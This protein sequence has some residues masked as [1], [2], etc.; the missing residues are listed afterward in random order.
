MLIV[1]FSLI[2]YTICTN[3]DEVLE[4][5]RVAEITIDA[6]WMLHMG[7]MFTTAFLK[8]VDWVTDIRQIAFNY[9]KANFLIDLVTTLPTLIT[10]YSVPDL[11]YLKLL[12]MYYIGR[13]T[14]IIKA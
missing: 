11:Y 4:V 7:M 1:D 8:D 13:S 6:I 9:L 10:F 2:P 5:T 3:V 14:Q 12:R